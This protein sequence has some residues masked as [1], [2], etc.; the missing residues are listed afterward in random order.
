MFSVGEL[1]FNIVELVFSNVELVFNDA[2]HNFL[3]GKDTNGT[4]TPTAGV[5]VFIIFRLT[6]PIEH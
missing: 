2:E 4:G 5:P 6:L 1:M 3:C